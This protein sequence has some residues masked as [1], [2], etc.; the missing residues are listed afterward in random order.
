MRALP[1]VACEGAP[2]REILVELRPVEAERRE[3][4]P[5]ELRFRPAFET[6][7]PG[8]GKRQ[9]EA[10][11]QD[12]ADLPVSIRSG[13]GPIDQGAHAKS[14]APRSIG[15]GLQMRVDDNLDASLGSHARAVTTWWRRNIAAR[16]DPAYS[17]TAF[18]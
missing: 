16:F 13:N 7:I 14:G 15:R 12:H 1:E 18:S 10:A 8:H 5:F 9:L 2:H 11:G 4:D 6:R 17:S 3:L